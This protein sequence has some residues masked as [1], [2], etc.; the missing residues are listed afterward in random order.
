MDAEAT[1]LASTLGLV[2][3]SLRDSEVPKTLFSQSWYRVADLKPRLRSHTQVLRHAYRDREW[4]VFQD[5]STGRFHRFSKEA[6]MMVGLMDGAR[7]MQSIWETACARL[8]DDMPTQDEAISLLSYLH[9]SDILQSDILPDIKDLGRRSRKE[10]MQRWLAK[11]RSPAAMSFSLWD[12]NSFLDKSIFLVRSLFTRTGFVVWCLF[13]VA[14]L[15]LFGA[16]WRELSSNVTERVLS[17]ESLFLLALIY[18]VARLL[19]ELGHAYTVKHFGGEVHEM[20]VMLIVFMPLPYVDA[21]WSSSFPRKYDRMLVGAAG[22]MTDLF[23][24]ALALIVWII[25]GPGVVRTLAYNVI[26]VAGLSTLL[27]NGNPLLRYDSYYILADA[28]EIP[29]LA[30]R[31]NKYLGYLLQRYLLRIPEASS[32]V[33]ARGER[34]WLAIYSIASSIYR[35][36]I[37]ISIAFFIAGKF[38][39]FGV[40]L[41]L[42]ACVS[43][44]VTPLIKLCRKVVTEMRQ[45]MA[46]VAVTTAAI[47]VPLL[48]F[49]FIVPL[50]SFTVT[51]GIVWVPEESQVFAGADGFVMKVLVAPGSRVSRGDP[52]VFCDSP[53]LKAE[54]RVLEANLS[55]VEARL[56]TSM[57][58][59]RTEVQILKDELE[60][61][62][63]KLSRAEERVSEMI[64]RSPATGVFVLPQ[65]ADWP[66]RFVHKGVPMGYVVDFSRTIVRVIVNQA[67]VDHVRRRTRKVEA[68]LV[69]AMPK[70]VNASIVR[71][72]P[73]ASKDL[74]S[75]ALSLQGG[76]AVALDPKESKEDRSPQAF[77]KLFHFDISLSG[78]P[79]AGVGERAYVRFDHIPESLGARAYRVVRRTLLK[80]LNV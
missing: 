72:V 53:E 51:E 21:S 46:R 25:A 15:L 76:G 60:R 56:R 37:T 1:K 3:D 2:M 33:Q 20:G 48:A 17:G 52:L 43:M 57:V 29:N 40:L 78:A 68:R 30:D 6:Y 54:T 47:A 27:L 7:S 26:F 62:R 10:K 50:P 11:V 12:P 39:A 74:P 19:H 9:Q 41:A 36:L 75:L 34:P 77:E 61:V 8:G 42:W 44:V 23:L 80:R 73:A 71:E 38:F 22:I 18:P 69:E 66:G 28:L 16:H 58:T 14:A 32:P 24:A 35:I 63:A 13:I 45:S 4:Y 55:E 65:A 59:N 31:G 64:V 79:A 49:F 5:I 67:D 70:I